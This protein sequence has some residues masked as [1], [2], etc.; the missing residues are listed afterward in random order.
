MRGEGSRS[1][2]GRSRVAPERATVK[3]RS[4]KS[5]E[6]VVAAR[7][8]RRAGEREGGSTVRATHGDGGA[9]VRQ[10]A[11]QQGI[12]LIHAARAEEGGHTVAPVLLGA[13]HREAGASRVCAIMGIGDVIRLHLSGA[14]HAIASRRGFR[15][16]GAMHR[17]AEPAS[18]R[19]GL[20]LREIGFLFSLVSH[21][22]T[23]G[24]G[25]SDTCT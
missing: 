25:R 16:T 17:F 22:Q 10:P 24:S 4:E 3:S 1:Y 18:R 7:T 6:A 11:P 15:H 14:R 21:Q 23:H 2:L 9:G 8:G 20:A 19:Q 12:E 13:Q 5:A